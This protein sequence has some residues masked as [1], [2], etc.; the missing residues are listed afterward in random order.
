MSK[1]KKKKSV[2]EPNVI[3]V[4]APQA[5]ARPFFVT[6]CLHRLGLP[7]LVLENSG[8]TQEVAGQLQLI[9]AHLERAYVIDAGKGIDVSTDGVTVK[10]L[11]SKEFQGITVAGRLLDADDKAVDV[12][13][14][15][16]IRKLEK[17]EELLALDGFSQICIENDLIGLDVVEGVIRNGLALLELCDKKGLLHG[18]AGYDPK[19]NSHFKT[20]TLQ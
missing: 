5:C 9:A 6:T 13:V 12:R 20:V 16:A 4:N 7:E 18:Q 17:E 14:R 19:M 3:W 8:I 1:K 15:G 11:R 10:L 2:E